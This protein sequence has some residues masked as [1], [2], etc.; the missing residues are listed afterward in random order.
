MVIYHTCLFL[1]MN[2]LQRGPSA[3]FL[4]CCQSHQARSVSIS[5]LHLYWL[6]PSHEAEISPLHFNNRHSL[7]LFPEPGTASLACSPPPQ[8]TPPGTQNSSSLWLRS[9]PCALMTPWDLLLK[10]ALNPSGKASWSA[11]PGTLGM[12]RDPVYP[13]HKHRDLCLQLSPSAH[14]MPTHTGV[15]GGLN[16]Q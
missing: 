13:S 9:L 14:T 7:T 3:R 11:V 1:C 10:K 4:R 8:A 16:T 15:P 2:R 12:L 6:R 5:N